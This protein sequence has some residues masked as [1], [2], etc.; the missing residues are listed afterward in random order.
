MSARASSNAPLASTTA[1]SIAFSS[2]RT[3]PCQSY[4]DNSAA[5]GDGVM[6]HGHMCTDGEYN[7]DCSPAAVNVL[8]LAHATHLACRRITVAP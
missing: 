6:M 8:G 5:L 3:F 7:Y 4:D 2:S 1:R